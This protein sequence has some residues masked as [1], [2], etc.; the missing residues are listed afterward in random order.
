[1]SNDPESTAA[2]KAAKGKLDLCDELL[3][4]HHQS[5]TRPFQ[6]NFTSLIQEFPEVKLL[7]LQLLAGAK[8]QYR[9]SETS[10]TTL[11]DLYCGIDEFL[12]SVCG[13]ESLSGAVDAVEDLNIQVARN[14]DAWLL[15]TYPARTLNRKRFGKVRAVVDYLKKNHRDAPRIG[16]PF[17]WPAAPKNTEEVSESYATEVFNALTKACLLDIK[18]VQAAMKSFDAIV[19]SPERVVD[20]QPTLEELI[21]TFGERELLWKSEGRLIETRP[22]AFENTIRK[23][24]TALKC[25]SAWGLTMN[26]FVS[27]YRSRRDECL[28]YDKVI[29]KMQIGANGLLKG[30][31]ASDSYRIAMATVA[32]T[33]P[34]WPIA[35]ECSAAND[36]FSFEGTI[37]GKKQVTADERKTYR[38]LQRMK[39]GYQTQNIEVGLMAYFAHF[40]FTAETIYPLFLYVQI[41]TGW[42]EEVVVS[43]TDSLEA[44]VEP[45]ICDPDYVLIWGDKRRVNKAQACRSNKSNPLSVYRI[46]RFIESVL[47][48]HRQ[49]TNY[50]PGVMW[51][52]VLNKNLWN[53]FQRVTT[54]LDNGN[55]GSISEGFLRRHGIVVDPEKKVQRI[56]ARRIR[57]TYETRRRESGLSLEEVSPLLGHP[58]ISTT[59]KNYD[60]DK[61]STELKNK[62]IRE[63]QTRMLDDFRHY[64]ARLISNRTLSELRDAIGEAESLSTK[65]SAVAAAAAHLNLT[66]EQTI[67]LLSPKG[68]T[69][70]AACIDRSEPTWPNARLFVP[71]GD[72]CTFFNRCCLCDKSLIFSEAL[73]YIARRIQDIQSLR[74]TIPSEEWAANYAEEGAAWEQILTDWLP[75]EDVVAAKSICNTQEYAL[76]L[77]MRGA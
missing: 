67:H 16:A 17:S 19:S 40:F 53:K 75:T 15:R 49:S 18:F 48:R 12:R 51:Q 42:N 36:L 63:L 10:Y 69:Y 35:M 14:F 24:P 56:E 6:R 28:Q 59:E 32:N 25:I 8:R 61:G 5:K 62:R 2:R 26:E 55:I 77:T 7:A 11:Q 38:V 66:Q 73:P 37:L 76:P 13:P 70:I 33:H 47:Q 31:S 27:T 58:D 9:N 54:S 46:L 64:S 1:M 4:V 44:H 34:N 39:F 20:R 22:S 57:T 43:L 71:I 60:S 72:D 23:S 52:F 50:L 45:D 30:Y 21:R 3:M 68:Q 74:L 29:S 41:N 65:E